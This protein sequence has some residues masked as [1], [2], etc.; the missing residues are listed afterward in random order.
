MN[1]RYMTA[2]SVVPPR[3]TIAD[4]VPAD[5][6]LVIEAHIRTD[7]ISRVAHGQPADIRL[8]AYSHRTTRLVSGHVFYIGADRS[9][10][11]NTQQPYYV[12]LVEAD[13]ASLAAAGDHVKLQAGMPAEVFIK[14]DERTA[15]QY[16]LEPMTAAMRRAGRER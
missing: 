15:L 8:T 10:D 14:G 11:R 1:L 9:V 4:I 5:P 13:P 12:A 2:G 7:D 3:E 16:L 6:R